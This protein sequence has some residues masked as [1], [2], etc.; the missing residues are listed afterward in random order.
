MRKN[1]KEERTVENLT[2]FTTIIIITRK[3]DD[4]TFENI[5]IRKS[6]IGSIKLYV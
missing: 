3:G 5:Q 2:N 4:K 6:R 1:K